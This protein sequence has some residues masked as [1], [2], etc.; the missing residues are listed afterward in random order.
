MDDVIAASDSRSA[1]QRIAQ[2]ERLLRH[3]R[4]AR[5]VRRSESR[6][7]HNVFV[8]G[9]DVLLTMLRLCNV[10]VGARVAINIVAVV[11]CR[12]VVFT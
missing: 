9:D 4:R 11:W 6:F 3:M 7:W 8:Y 1:R 12:G 10:V 5:I 2:Q